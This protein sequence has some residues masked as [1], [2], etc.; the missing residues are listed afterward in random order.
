MHQMSPGVERA[1]SAA[2]VWAERLGTTDLKLSHFVLALLDEEEGRPAVLLERAGLSVPIVRECLKALHDAQLAPSDN[3]LFNAARNW[4]LAHRYDPEFLTDAFLIAVIRANPEF[5]RALATFGLNSILL[6]QLLHVGTDDQTQEKVQDPSHP[7]A[8]FAQPD[9]T[10]EIDVARVMDANFN[11]AREAARAL[12]DYCRFIRNDR[13]L[14]EQIKD[15]RHNL[16]ELCT[17]FPPALLLTARDTLQDVGTTVTASSEYERNSPAQVATANLKRL[18]ESLRT[19]EEFGKLFAQQFGRDFESLRYRA[20][21]LEKALC[22]G[23]HNREKLV[24]AR[25]YALLTGSQCHSSLDWTVERA[26]AGGVDIVQLR[27]K[28]LSD[29]ELLARAR[30]MRRWTQ[31]AGVLF[32]LNDRPEIARLCDA[33][34]VHLGQ[35]DLSI[36]DARRILG[37]NALIGKSTHNIEQVRQ[38]ILDGADYLGIGPVFPSSTKTFDNFPGLEFVRAASAETSLAA[39]ALGGITTAN[40]ERVVNAG[41]KRIAV[42]SAIAKAEDPE[43][44]SRLFRT[45]IGNH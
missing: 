22:G 12:E 2:R 41:A 11:R 37:G 45:I 3:E 13:F 10:G 9:S 17:H 23:S 30:D 42:G 26:A 40:L 35:D 36:Q 39:F 19:L 25:L 8:V 14:T 16:A 38:A 6:E 4:S 43:Q 15:L 24:K 20:Y 27:E 7:L 34:G 28:T 33:D 31:K 29:R 5:E 18:Q 44:V 32:I 1:V 21:T